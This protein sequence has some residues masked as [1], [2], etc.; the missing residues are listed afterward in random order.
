[1]EA[2]LG[3]GR[4]AG[5]QPGWIHCGALSMAVD[6]LQPL[7]RP[8][9]LRRSGRRVAVLSLAAA[10]VIGFQLGGLQWRYRQQ[11]W[12]LQG[13]VVGLVIGHLIGRMDRPEPDE[14]ARRG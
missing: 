13:L 7:E 5:S 12:Q 9:R 2:W 14:G 4:C 8:G 3:A 11:L 10:A 6:P 1:M